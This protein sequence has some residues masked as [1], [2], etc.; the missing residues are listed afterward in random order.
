MTDKKKVFKDSIY[1]LL[2]SKKTHIQRWEKRSYQLHEDDNE[3]IWKITEDNHLNVIH[4]KVSSVEVVI[5]CII[6]YAEGYKGNDQ[7]Q[8]SWSVN[9][10]HKIL[11]HLCEEKEK[12]NNTKQNN[13][14]AWSMKQF[15]MTEPINKCHWK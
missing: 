11:S 9:S 10:I 5:D 6:E 4:N 15:S 2:S 7:V 13:H 1:M 8:K 3:N 12:L 14:K